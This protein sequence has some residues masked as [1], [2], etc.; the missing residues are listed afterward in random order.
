MSARGIT[1]ARFPD[2]NATADDVRQPHSLVSRYGGAKH[3]HLRASASRTCCE[4]AAPERMEAA[5]AGEAR[6]TLSDGHWTSHAWHWSCRSTAVAA[7]HGT[8]TAADVVLNYGSGT[9]D[10]DAL[11]GKISE[12]LAA[13]GIEA[14]I[15]ITRTGADLR[16]ACERAAAS[17]ARIV[18]AGG[19]DGTIAT[20]AGHIAAS[21]KSLGVLP[22]GTF[23][24]FAR[25][26]GLPLD[27]DDALSVLTGST[28]K[29]VDVG[30]VNGHIFLNNSSIGLYPAVL[31]KRE[32]T[33]RRFGRSQIVAHLSV[34][35]TL[36]EPPALVNLT[37][38]AD[39]RRLSRRTPLLFIGANAEQMESLGIVGGECVK[40]RKLTLYITQPLGAIAIGRLALQLLLRRLRRTQDFEVICAEEIVIGLRRRRVRVALDGEIRLIESPLR[41]RILR[42]ALRVIVPPQHKTPSETAD[43]PPRPVAAV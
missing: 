6:R 20:V 23:N 12:R 42:D 9:L 15:A 29:C 40:N 4:A 10:K 31:A 19:G 33:Y 2:S 28:T 13:G 26:L 38:S 17:D 1:T 24:Y 30:E 35:L 25:T 37:V 22:L 27:V 41:Y 36:V 43:A 39:G 18:I 21:G 8:R 14:R 7:S 16:A 34:L 3:S 11:A 32:S 5:S